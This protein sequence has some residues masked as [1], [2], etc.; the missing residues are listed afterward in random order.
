VSIFYIVGKPRGGKSLTAVKDIVTELMNPDSKRSVVTNI[1]LFFGDRVVREN[2]PLPF[3][4]RVFGWFLKWFRDVPEHGIVERTVPGLASYLHKRCSHEINLAERVRILEDDETGEFWL[5]EPGKDYLGRKSIKLNRRSGSEID[6]PDFEERGRE[7]LGNY[8]TKYVIDEVHLFFPAREWQRTGPDA[9]FFL[10][11]HGKLKCDVTLITQH[12]DQCDKALRRLAQEYMSVRNLSREPVLGFRVGNYFRYLRTLASPTNPSAE[13]FESGF[14][15]L[16]EDLKWL[17]DTTQ[18]VG[19][20]GG[21]VPA[22]EK[23]GRSLWWL[24][25]PLV[26]FAVFLYYCKPIINGVASLAHLGASKA[27]GASMNLGSRLSTNS[28]SLSHPPFASSSPRT[29]KVS[30]VA[31]E[32]VRARPLAQLAPG[33]CD[34]LGPVGSFSGSGGPVTIS[35]LEF[36]GVRSGRLSYRVMLSDG[37][38]L[39]PANSQLEL[40]DAF[41]AKISGVYYPTKIWPNEAKVL[42]DSGLAPIDVKGP[43]GTVGASY[44]SPATAI[45][46]QNTKTP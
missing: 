19:V 29:E 18:G 34:S 44:P 33:P 43:S 12:P 45:A 39:V 21:L 27:V 1:R 46:G 38:V 25:I 28:L 22:Q 17:Y 32:P 5:F 40:L 26:G 14:M 7:D 23:R 15:S 9:T 35:R 20:V 10:S 24:S 36:Y 6:V 2:I 4:W 41:G 8:G 3:V 31:I 13:V 11:Q 42:P 16:D 30:T 37:R